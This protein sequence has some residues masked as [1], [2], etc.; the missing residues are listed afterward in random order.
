[1]TKDQIS[2]LS[3][4]S[5]SHHLLNRIAWAFC[6]YLEAVS[7]LPQLR[8]MQNTK[9]YKNIHHTCCL[10]YPILL[11]SFLISF[12]FMLSDC[13]AIHSTLCICPGCRK[14]LEL[15]SLGS[16]GMICSSKLVIALISSM[17]H[18]QIQLSLHFWLVWSAIWS[19]K[20]WNVNIIIICNF[21]FGFHFQWHNNQLSSVSI[22][23][24]CVWPVT[25]IF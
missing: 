3:P 6:V 25:D 20:E 8:V 11:S 14:I 5:T 23:V 1:M 19:I 17:N 18:F 9:V 4:P 2:P 21:K 13:W 24:S 7:V 16:S 10:C 12:Y 15:C 22:T